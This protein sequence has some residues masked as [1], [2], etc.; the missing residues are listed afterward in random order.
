MNSSTIIPE[1]YQVIPYSG[2]FADDVGPFHV[3]DLGDKD[4]RYGFVAETRHTN[5]NAVVHGGMLNT[6]ADHFIGHAVVHRT[7]RM[8]AT[9]SLNADYVSGGKPNTWI[10]GRADLVRATRSLI[11]MRGTV[12]CA[13]ETLLSVNGVWRLFEEFTAPGA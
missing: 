9:I 3:I 1:G 12:Y 10:E 8:G 5:P 11:F 13:G 6:F 7:G 2:D 4:F